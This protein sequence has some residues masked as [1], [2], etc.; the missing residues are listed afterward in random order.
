MMPKKK[1]D[2]S[3]DNLVLLRKGNK[4]PTEGDIKTTCGV[5][6]EENT[7]QRLPQLMSHPIYSYKTQT[8]LLMPTSRCSMEL[9][10]AVTWETLLVHHKYRG[11]H[12]QPALN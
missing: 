8:L 3:M 9:D 5:E 1:E 6:T 12:S 10:I 2:Q 4:I 11:E 7:I